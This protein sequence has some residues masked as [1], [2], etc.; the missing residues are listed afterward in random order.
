M[1]TKDAIQHFGSVGALAAAL[2]IK[3]QAIYQWPETVPAS[4]QFEVEVKSGGALKAAGA[5]AGHIKQMVTA[6]P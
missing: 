6:A 3:R 5:V 2:G 1:K 4:R